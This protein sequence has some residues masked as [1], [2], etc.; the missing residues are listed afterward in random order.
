[1]AQAEAA[2][3]EAR[4]SELDRVQTEGR[5]REAGMEAQVVRLMTQIE[6]ARREDASMVS[7]GSVDGGGGAGTLVGRENYSLGQ[8]HGPSTCS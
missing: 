2:L 7:E 8:D 4:Q 6:D 3:T 1:M 5:E